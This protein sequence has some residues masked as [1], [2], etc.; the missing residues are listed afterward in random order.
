M[1]RDRNDLLCYLFRQP[2]PPPI[3]LKEGT[4]G[5]GYFIDLGDRPPLMKKH[6]R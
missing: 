5:E 1:N 3:P 6:K 4:E 2:Q